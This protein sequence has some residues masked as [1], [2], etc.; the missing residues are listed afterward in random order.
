MAMVVSLVH[1]NERFQ[2]AARQLVIKSGFKEAVVELSELQD[3][4]RHE[5]LAAHASKLAADQSDATAQTNYGFHLKNGDSIPIDKS[6]AADWYKLA[7]D[8]GSAHAQRNYGLLLKNGDDIPIDKSLAA[9]YF[10]LAADQGYADA[11][12]TGVLS[13]MDLQ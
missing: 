3:V 1:P 12:F 6:L 8:Q 4:L 2:V 11:Q 9:H 7:A 10:K 5:S 13:P